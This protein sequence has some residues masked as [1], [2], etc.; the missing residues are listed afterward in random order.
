M[1]LNTKPVRKFCQRKYDLNKDKTEFK[2]NVSIANF[3]AEDVI[4]LI[5]VNAHHIFE[6]EGHDVKVRMGGVRLQ[7]LAREPD[8]Q[9][10]GIKGTEFRVELS[11]NLS[12]HLNL[13]AL[14]K[15]GHFTMLTRDHIIPK[16]KGG[17]GTLDNSQTLCTNCNHSKGDKKIGRGEDIRNYYRIKQRLREYRSKDLWA[18]KLLLDIDKLL[19]Q[20]ERA[21][22]RWIYDSPTKY[23]QEPTLFKLLWAILIGKEYHG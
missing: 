10:C 19:N 21:T 23:Y 4:P 18:T 11:A 3:P 9:A 6:I 20:Q 16:S 17:N 2:Q 8:C 5:G 13:Y 22:R 15:Y 14:N 7:T 1:A 12:P